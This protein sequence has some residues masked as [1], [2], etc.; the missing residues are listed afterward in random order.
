[1]TTRSI[2]RLALTG[3]T[4]F[5]GGRIIAAALE[6]GI[7]VAALARSPSKL[8]GFEDRIDIVTGGLGDDEALRRLVAGADVLINCAGLTHALTPADF[9]RVNVDGALGAAKAAAEAGAFF[10]QISSMAARESAVSPYAKSK[11]LSEDAARDGSGDNPWISLRLPAIYGPADQATL[12]LFKMVKA[13]IAPEPATPS[14][15][16]ASILH[17]D[18]VAAAI[19]CAAQEAPPGDVYEI[20]DDQPDGHAWRD[21]GAALAG[22][23]GRKVWAFRAP[24]FLME[25]QALM[26][27]AWGR[28]RGEAAF[29]SRGKVAEFFHPDWVARDNLLS[30]H[31]SWTATT[32][33]AEGFAKT[34]RWYQEE[35]SL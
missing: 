8:M 32:S 4:G 3:G 15:A 10:V 19:I 5:V 34:L 11:R 24:R 12:S 22:A 1:M 13:G 28:L 17:V 6:K 18:D 29:V 27:E 20:G 25:A 30:A 2:R 31:T 9:Q 35:G 14:P 21:I 23:M 7:D 33:L 16:R 26:G